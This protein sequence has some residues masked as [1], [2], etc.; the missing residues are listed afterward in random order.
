MRIEKSHLG[1]KYV[2]FMTSSPFPFLCFFVSGLAILIIM[3]SSIELNI[4]DTYPASLESDGNG[5]TV[6]TNHDIPTG[7]AFAYTNRNEAMIQIT[8]ADIK[9][10]DGKKHLEISKADY[11]ALVALNGILSLDVPSGKESLLHRVFA[12]GGKANE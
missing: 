3:A 8:I 9:V 5:I 11:A 7:S 10:K 4:I 1:T 12:K 2:H 6:V